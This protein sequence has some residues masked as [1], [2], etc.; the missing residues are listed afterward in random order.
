MLAPADIRYPA[1]QEIEAVCTFSSLLFDGVKMTLVKT[2]RS[3]RRRDFP[4]RNPCPSSITSASSNATRAF[5]LTPIRLRSPPTGFI[6]CPH[7]KACVFPILQV[8]VEEVR[9]HYPRPLSPLATPPTS[10]RVAY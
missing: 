10:P 7:L 2:A 3:S 9:D 8:G 1:R 4:Q 5:L 6:C